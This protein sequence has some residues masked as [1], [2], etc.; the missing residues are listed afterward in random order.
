[1]KII[2]IP[3]DKYG[4]RS[5]SVRL[6]HLIIHS[7]DLPTAASLEVLTRSP[8]EVSCHYLISPEG[9]IYRMVPEE[10]RAWHA[11]KSYW[12]GETDINSASIGIELVWPADREAAEDEI[13]GPFPDAQME[14]LV[15]LAED[16]IRRHGI[17]PEDVLA[18]SD[19]APGRKR[20]PGERFEWK[21]LAEAGLVIWP[22][23]PYPI[24]PTGDM[25]PL[26]KRYGYDVRDVHAAVVAF[27]K[28][29]R[30]RDCTGIA[31]SETRSMLEWLLQKTKR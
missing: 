13:P 12:R 29:F 26:L 19:I 31:D 22:Q 9:T 5:E 27:Q 21:R 16:I 10:K 20:D 28:H 18:H 1:M 7:T 30:P 24:P 15:E 17:K 8:R 14:A 3:T 25:E 11:G 6:K 4:E 23:R 2:D